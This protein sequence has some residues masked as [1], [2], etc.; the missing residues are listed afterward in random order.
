[1]QEL[2]DVR[3]FMRRKFRKYT[4]QIFIVSPNG[5]EFSEKMV[6][7]NSATGSELNYSFDEWKSRLELRKQFPEK[8]L[9]LI[10][11]KCREFINYIFIKKSKGGNQ[12]IFAKFFVNFIPFDVQ[13]LKRADH[14]FF[15]S[16]V[17]IINVAAASLY[18]HTSLLFRIFFCLIILMDRVSADD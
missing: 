4:N 13:C 17:L 15:V 10:V 16:I 1:M 12:I 2:R 18:V 9:S 14:D 7:W 11:L 3:N 6:I 5:L 8:F